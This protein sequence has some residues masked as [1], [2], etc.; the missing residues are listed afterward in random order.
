MLH[1]ILFFVICILLS[2]NDQDSVG[3][4]TLTNRNPDPKLNEK[5]DP[6]QIISDKLCFTGIQRWAGLQ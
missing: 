2:V 3:F 1:T 5:L 4:E 6:E